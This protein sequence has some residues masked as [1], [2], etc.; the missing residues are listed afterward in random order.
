MRGENPLTIHKVSAA[1][2]PSD[3]RSDWASESAAAKQ[4]ENYNI[5]SL[6]A[7]SRSSYVSVL[8]QEGVFF[9]GKSQIFLKI[10]VLFWAEISALG[11]FLNF[12]NKRMYPLN[13]E[14]PPPPPPPPPGLYDRYDQRGDVTHL[15]T[16]KLYSLST[17]LSMNHN[18]M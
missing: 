12:D 17:F 8:I 6:N 13:T 16:N 2:M 7:C 5:K 3:Y 10:R 1:L 18:T 4:A 11:V 15:C 9:T 14:V